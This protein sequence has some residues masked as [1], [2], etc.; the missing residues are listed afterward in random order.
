MIIGTEI[1]LDGLK[2]FKLQLTVDE[3]PATPKE[4]IL[5]ENDARQ[6]VYGETP[7]GY[8]TYG[9][10]SKVASDGHQPGCRWTSRA[11]IFNGKFK[12][13]CMEVN[14]VEKN[15]K[16]PYRYSGN[17]TVEA[18]LPYLPKGFY[19]LEQVETDSKGNVSEVSYYISNPN[20]ERSSYWFENINYDD[21]SKRFI[22][23]R[24]YN[25]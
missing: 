5:F 20:H 17:M 2:L 10:I 15:G 13:S 22:R 7:E 12:K 4:T 1:I 25:L 23:N 18:V 11:S 6:F 16:Y 19:I 21:G 3:M 8:V 9:S 14:F 24:I